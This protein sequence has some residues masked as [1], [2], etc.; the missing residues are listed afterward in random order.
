M[1]SQ[2][3]Q[4]LIFAIPLIMNQGLIQLNISGTVVKSLLDLIEYI[5]HSS[6]RSQYD[7]FG[8]MGA[9]TKTFDNRIANRMNTRKPKKADFNRRVLKKI[10]KNCIKLSNLLP[11]SFKYLLKNDAGSEE[12][13]ELQ[14]GDIVSLD[15]MDLSKTPK[16]SFQIGNSSWTKPRKVRVNETWEN[17]TDVI[18]PSKKSSGKQDTLLTLCL[19][20]SPLVETT[21][22]STSTNALT[23]TAP[24]SYYE[25]ETSKPFDINNNS[26]SNRKVIIQ[27]CVFSKAILIDRSRIGLSI[28]S[29]YGYRE[30]TRNTFEVGLLHS[31]T[32]KSSSSSSSSNTIQYGKKGHILPSISKFKVTS[33]KTY[34]ISTASI[35]SKVYSDSDYKWTHLQ[36]FLSDENQYIQTPDA[37]SKTY[38]KELLNFSLVN[39]PAF[40]IIFMDARTKTLPMWMIEEGYS[41]AFF[42]E[43]AVAEKVGKG[44]IASTSV[45]RRYFQAWGKYYNIDDPIAMGGNCAA[46]NSELGMFTVSIIDPFS[47]RVSEKLSTEM[48]NQIGYNFDYDESSWSEGG[49]SVCMFHS[50]DGCFQIGDGMGEHWS[51][52]LHLDG[53][54]NT[55][56]PFEIINKVIIKNSF[57]LY[58]F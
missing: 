10:S 18:F 42:A 8:R 52:S 50:S 40:V 58:F 56:E 28:K 57:F 49:S 23:N 45:E 33:R 35:G 24:P 48:A 41:R 31:M 16:L 46:A 43:P 38:L 54:N 55:K 44:T 53:M 17:T 9:G 26:S 4:S 51:A 15:S 36:S 21:T 13:G 32:S 37:D 30:Y 14:P 27:Y 12:S 19:T 34:K 39:K 20:S 22:T 29:R 2:T 7:R 11:V 5:K 3:N 25:P 6:E 1:Q 47:S